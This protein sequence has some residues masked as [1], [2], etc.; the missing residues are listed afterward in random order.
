MGLNEIMTALANKIREI[1]GTT[2]ALGLEAMSIK[3]EEVNNEVD[4]QTDIIALIKEAVNALPEVIET[5]TFY[6]DGIPYTTEKGTTW[7][8]WVEK[9]NFPQIPTY[10]GTHM[11]TSDI[12]EAKSYQSGGGAV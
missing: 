8:E 12:I 10:N 6:I 7:G 11:L 1:S 9:N 2:S 3:A 4:K 5:I